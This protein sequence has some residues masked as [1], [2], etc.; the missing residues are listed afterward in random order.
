MTHICG[1]AIRPNGVDSVTC[2]RRKRHIGPHVNMAEAELQRY[3]QRVTA[4]LDPETPDYEGDP[5]DLDKPAGTIE[6]T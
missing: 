2:L 3:R 4:H 1:S 6:W 5:Q